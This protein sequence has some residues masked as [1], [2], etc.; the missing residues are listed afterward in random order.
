RQ[1]NAVTDPFQN[2]RGYITVVNYRIESSDESDKAK[3]RQQVQKEREDKVRIEMPVDPNSNKTQ[4]QQFDYA[5]LEATYNKLKADKAQL[6]TER[7]EALKES[8]ELAK[9]RDAYLKDNVIGLTAEQI[10]KLIER[11]NKFDYSLRQINVNGDQIVD[12]CE[13]CHLGV[14]EPLELRPANFKLPRK[15]LDADARAFVSHPSKELLQIHSPERFGCSSCHGGN[16]RATTSIVKGHGKNRFWL[17]PLYDR[18]NMEAGCQQCHS[19]DRVLQGANVLTKGKDLFQERGCVGC[20]RYEGFDRETDGLSNARQSIKQLEEQVAAN[21]REARQLDAEAGTVA[22]ETE[23]Q[24]KLARAVSLRVT[25]S[26]LEARIEQL[27][28]SARYLMQD[29]KKVGPNLKDVRLKLKKEWIPVWLKDPQAFRPGTKMPTFWYLNPD[30]ELSKNLK[31]NSDGERAAIAAYLW[32]SAFDGQVPKQDAGDA[33]HGKELFETKGCMA[34]HS[35][36]EDVDSQVGGTFAANL[37]RVGEKADFNYIVRWIYNPR[38]RYAPYCPKEKRDL[39]RED[40]EKNGKPY[41]FDTNGHSKCPNDGAELQVQNMTVMPNFRLSEQDSRDIATYLF[42]LGKQ[43]QWPDASFMD[44]PKLKDQGAYLIK[45]YGC[46]NCHEIKGFEDEQRIGKELSAEGSTPI[47]RLDFAL[48]TKTAEENVNPFTGKKYTEEERKEENWYN[49]KGFFE[50]KLEEPGIYDKGKEKDPKDHLRMPDPYLRPEWKTA[51]T[52]FLLGS[53]GAEGANVPASFFYNPSDRGKDI[54]D[55]WWVIKKYNCMGCHTVQVGQ[56]SV[57]QE[58]PQFLTPEGKD[59]LPPALTTEGARV[60]PNWLLRFLTDPSLSG[61]GA[62]GDS[63]ASAHSGMTGRNNGGQA[64]GGGSSNAGA[65]ASNQPQGG[66]PPPGS[67]PG[68][69]NV[70]VSRQNTDSREL[71]PQPGVNRNGVRLYLKP[72]MPT[73][74]FSPNELRT[75]VRFFLA[76]SSQQEP[77]IKEPVETLTEQERTLARQ[78]FTSQQAPCLKCH[79]TGNPEH[80]KNASAPNFL[81]ASERLKR[82]WTF[83]WLLDPQKV[84][85][86]TAMPSELFKRDGERWVFNGQLPD[87]FNEFHGDHADLLVRYILQLTPAEQARLA[88]GSPS[89]TAGTTTTGETKNAVTQS[90]TH[91]AATR[92]GGASARRG[93]YRQRASVRAPAASRRKARGGRVRDT[94]AFVRQYGGYSPQAGRSW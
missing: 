33:S 37:T 90:S 55:G 14:R 17:H 36:G 86:G 85:P 80:D 46:A 87:S 71:Q 4:E 13:T 62:A 56:K 22:D 54:Q 18:E 29:Q 25:N 52:T 51:L 43:S 59:Q 41:V 12:R 35:I 38:E 21:N 23:A 53:V 68:G 8:D 66:A 64:S 27:N 60:D 49:H 39:T 63:T 75:L 32:Q 91:H 16:G 79:L 45:Q 74:N 11:N 81:Q 92:A 2:K 10:D 65:T 30:H 57:I 84:I 19:S 42:S 83:R 31:Q 82:G 50:H 78:L 28:V 9:K 77:F 88:S 58:L 7:A 34:C 15:K 24:R 26:Q 44:D 48:L 20:H 40:Y 47:K 70:G 76:V 89:A 69:A 1:L 67:P 72:R 3:L 5:T 73:F 93:K 6:L 61:T 94:V